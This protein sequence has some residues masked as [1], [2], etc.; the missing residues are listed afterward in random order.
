MGLSG[1]TAGASSAP[2]MSSIPSFRNSAAS[3][4]TAPSN[5]GSVVEMTAPNILILPKIG[6]P[7]PGQVNPPVSLLPQSFHSSPASLRADAI[8]IPK[9]IGLR[10]EPDTSKENFGNAFITSPRLAISVSDIVRGA[11][12]VSNVLLMPSSKTNSPIVNTPLTTTPPNTKN[13]PSHSRK[14][15][16]L[17][18]SNQIPIAT[19]I[20]AI[21]APP[22]STPCVKDLSSCPEMKALKIEVMVA[23][24]AFLFGLV[25]LTSYFIRGVRHFWKSRR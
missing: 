8:W 17:G 23:V 10:S 3:A 21:I 9:S 18:L 5:C 24:G 13:N 2:W 11:S 12:R 14:F 15:F 25:A 16:S 6:Y 1:H 20:S 7:V 22:N 19:R 4:F